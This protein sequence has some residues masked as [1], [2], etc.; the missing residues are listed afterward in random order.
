MLLMIFINLPNNFF[1]NPMKASTVDNL[2]T[3]TIRGLLLLLGISPPAIAIWFQEALSSYLASLSPIQLLQLVVPLLAVCTI[4]L[5]FVI[6]LRPWLRWDEK[7]GTWV[8]RLSTIHFC[9]KCI[10]NNKLVPLKNE[11]TGWRCMACHSWFNDPARIPKEKKA[12]A[13]S[14]VRI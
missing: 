6:Y 3:W 10:S 1:L 9:T 2:K 12:N 7:T 14:H 4:S 5:S 11:V 13:N 8:N